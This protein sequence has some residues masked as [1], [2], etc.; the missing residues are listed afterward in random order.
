MHFYFAWRLPGE[1]FFF[2]GQIFQLPNRSVVAEDDGRG[3]DDLRENIGE[4]RGQ[5]VR[6]LGQG[7][8]YE[9]ISVSIHDQRRDSIRFAIDQPVSVGFSDHNFTVAGR[10]QE[11]F[12][13]ET[14]IDGVPGPGDEAKGDLRAIAVKAL[15]EKGPAFFLEADQVPR[16]GI[17]DLIQVIAKDPRMDPWRTR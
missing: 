2:R 1:H 6:A 5:A 8:H 17:L 11:A 9:V 7:L 3:P 16:R 15:G 4:K 12:I 10:S 13:P 14:T